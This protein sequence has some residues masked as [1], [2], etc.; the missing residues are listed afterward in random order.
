MCIHTQTHTHKHTHTHTHTTHTYTH[1][2]L[3][4]KVMCPNLEVRLGIVPIH[5][6]V[7]YRQIKNTN[8]KK[9]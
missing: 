4:P 1:R 7:L 5:V 2:D 8:K 6:V 9:I 3:P